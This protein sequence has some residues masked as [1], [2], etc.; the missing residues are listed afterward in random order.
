MNQD[1]ETDATNAEAVGDVDAIQSFDQLYMALSTKFAG[2]T[3]I[4]SEV[5]SLAE[6]VQSLEE[7]RHKD[8]RALADLINDMKLVKG[9]NASVASPPGMSLG[10]SANVTTPADDEIGQSSTTAGAR[11]AGDSMEK[12]FKAKMLVSLCNVDKVAQFNGEPGTDATEW[13]QDFIDK[14]GLAGATDEFRLK[15]TPMNFHGVAKTWYANHKEQLTDWTTFVDQFLQYFCPDDHRPELLGE[16]LYTRRQRLN[17]SALHYYDDV[18]RLC[19]KFNANMSAKDRVDILL[20]GTRLEARDWMEIRNP[21][22]PAAFL[23]LLSE[24]ERRTGQKLVDANHTYLHHVPDR[25]REHESGNRH[26][27]QG[28]PP[29]SFHQQQTVPTNHQPHRN[30]AQ[31]ESRVETTNSDRSY[32]T[33]NNSYRRWQGNGQ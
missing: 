12:S 14:S 3:K 13:L 24:Y 11:S 16:R 26:P 33:R 28:P 6:Q 2:M 4:G 17:E 23:K 5:K 10:G 31:L 27:Y 21:T 29:P 8:Q 18:M 25:N 30:A 15:A 22:T 7:Q 20:K 32:P 19:A 9:E 1:G